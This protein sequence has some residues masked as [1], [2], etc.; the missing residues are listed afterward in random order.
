M[1][2]ERRC[3]SRTVG[4]END[5]HFSV[6]LRINVSFDVKVSVENWC[7]IEVS[8]LLPKMYRDGASAFSN[9]I[10]RSR[11]ECQHFYNIKTNSKREN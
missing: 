10:D 11:I 3:D 5:E 1:H 4:D 8:K 7:C 2:T 9:Q 6:Q